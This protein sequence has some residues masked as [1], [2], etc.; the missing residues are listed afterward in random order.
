[1]F[2]ILTL[3]CI[4]VLRLLFGSLMDATIS[5]SFRQF[6]RSR[7]GRNVADLLARDDLGDVGSYGGGDH[8]AG[9]KTSKYPVIFV[10]GMLTSA[11][12]TQTMA[13]FFQSSGGYSEEELYATTFGPRGSLVISGAMDCQYS[14]TIRYMIIAV[15]EYTNS[16]VN[17]IAYSMGVPVSRKAILGGNCVEGGDLG[18]GTLT[19][20]VNTFLGVAGPNNGA[21]GCSLPLASFLTTC[22]SINGLRCGSAFLSDI[23]SRQHYEGQYV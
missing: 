9:Q 15:S 14:Q 19:Q 23:N 5:D 22:N 1:M 13:S 20:Y 11:G 17:V 16:P 4:F 10:H 6:I 2:K 21:L 3:E 18:R 8:V 12:T 7:Y